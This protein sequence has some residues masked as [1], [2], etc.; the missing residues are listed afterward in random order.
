MT[1]PVITNLEAIPDKTVTVGESVIIECKAEGFPTP[2]Y[3]W[4]KN[5]AMVSE[6][7]NLIIVKT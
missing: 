6:W 5:S 2:E 7:I 4:S 1:I 3:Q